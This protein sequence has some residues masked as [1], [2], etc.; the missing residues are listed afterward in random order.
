M[1]MSYVFT[2]KTPSTDTSNDRLLVITQG[3]LMAVVEPVVA[4]RIERDVKPLLQ[5]YFTKWGRYPFA[6]PFTS[7]PV[8][9]GAYLGASSQTMGLLPVTN[10]AT[11]TWQTPTVT[12]IPPGDGSSTVTSS[13]CSI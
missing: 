8:A 11:F 10:T 7:P 3:D 13:S 5:D 12:Q 6:V 1:N 4:A 2:S 9:Q